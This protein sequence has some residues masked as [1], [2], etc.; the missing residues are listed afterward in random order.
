MEF[1]QFHPSSLYIDE[2]ESSSSSEERAF[3]ITEALRGAGARLFN[4]QGE[5]FMETYDRKRMELAPRD[6]VAR[7]IHHELVTSGSPC[8]FLDISHE[9]AEEVRRSFPAIYQ[10]CMSHGIDITREPIPVV[11]AAHYSCGGVSVDL[12][13]HT[14]IPS[15]YA[16]GEVACSGCHGANRLASN[17]LLE[18][19]VFG[20]RAAKAVVKSMRRSPINVADM[21]RLDLPPL[22]QV[23]EVN[24]AGIDSVEHT[25]QRFRT[26]MTAVMFQYG[27]IV[28]T[29]DGLEEGLMHLDM[30]EREATLAGIFD[31]SRV[32]KESI[33]F[34]NLL[35]VGKL[36]LFAAKQR[37][38]SRGLHYNLDFLESSETWKK[39]IVLN[40]RALGMH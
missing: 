29:S 2:E 3:L 17:S 1:I 38:E 34:Q 4:S 39:D 27:G 16:C 18:A 35:E 21:A 10:R 28:R 13:G 5:R 7:A 8:V 15:L 36:V 22:H 19:I 26:R 37:K 14:S 33:E 25:V 30:I 11:P 40:K 12:N 24:T 6:V 9:P 31:R 20:H 32:T 23:D